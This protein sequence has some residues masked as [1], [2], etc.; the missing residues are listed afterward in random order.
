MPVGDLG[1]LNTTAP[2]Y[3]KRTLARRVFHDKEFVIAWNLWDFVFWD[4]SYLTTLRSVNRK[5]WP[6]LYIDFLLL[7]VSEWVNNQG[8]RS[9]RIPCRL[10]IWFTPMTC[11]TVYL[12]RKK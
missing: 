9:H 1:F 12:I 4:K 5:L 7:R 8:S 2:Q 3:A 10:T 11:Y 6:L